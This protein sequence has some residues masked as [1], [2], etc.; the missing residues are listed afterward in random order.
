MTKTKAKAQR[1]NLLDWLE[2]GVKPKIE[3]EPGPQR[4]LLL[5][6]ECKRRS[7]V[8]DMATQAMKNLTLI[9]KQLVKVSE[10]PGQDYAKIFRDEPVFSDM[11]L[12]CSKGYEIG[13]T[14][15]VGDEELQDVLIEAGM[16]Y[17][18][19]RDLANKSTHDELLK[20]LMRKPRGR[21]LLKTVWAKREAAREKPIEL[22]LRQSAITV[23]RS[24]QLLDM[25]YELHPEESSQ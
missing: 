2:E 21:E 8:C 16:G 3:T 12:A 11:L 14:S 5:K 6:R 24:K 19:K 10:H 17:H 4:T 13:F 22:I 20:Q 9:M 23:A 18:S 7:D 15:R 1:R 25:W